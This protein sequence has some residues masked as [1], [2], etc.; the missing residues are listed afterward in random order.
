MKSYLTN[1][2]Y[3]CTDSLDLLDYYQSAIELRE[4]HK[5]DSEKIARL[6]FDS[7]HPSKLSFEPP[8]LLT[9]IRNE[10]GALEAPG[11]PSDNTD[12][13]TY[14]DFLWRRLEIMVNKKGTV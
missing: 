10:F 2:D 14:R 4:L 9:E 8:R 5:D 6:V 1:L 13:D 3:I 7:T 11:M 12:P